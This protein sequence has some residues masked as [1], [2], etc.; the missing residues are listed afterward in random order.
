ML[1]DVLH[2]LGIETHTLFTLSRPVIYTV[3]ALSAM[4]LIGSAT[5]RAIRR[6]RLTG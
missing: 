5:T 6:R 4:A 3:L 2:A 1:E